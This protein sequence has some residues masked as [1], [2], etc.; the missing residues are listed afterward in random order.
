M[1]NRD[2]D[3]KL[4]PLWETCKSV[5]IPTIP[6]KVVTG[7]WGA[8]L[9]DTAVLILG[10][11][12]GAQEDSAG[13][14]FIG[15]SG[16]MLKTAYVDFFG[17]TDLADVYLGNAVRCRPPRN[18]TPKKKNITACQRYLESD[19]TDLANVYIKVYVLAVGAVPAQA[20]GFKSLR[21]ALSAQGIERWKNIPVFATFHP[22]Y[23]IR[24]PSAALQVEAHMR[25]F[26][27][28][29]KGEKTYQVD[30]STIDILEA[31]DVQ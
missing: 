12:P 11:A 30:A 10:E 14:P 31:P 15:P 28:H 22:A 7:D 23:L 16:K 1:F 8:P 17:L 19:L 5:C 6:Y 13:E 18:D 26:V 29:L 20:C 21:A 3:C 27:A 25:S 24:N 2:V 4:C 9:K